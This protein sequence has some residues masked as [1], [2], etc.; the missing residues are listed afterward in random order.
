MSISRVSNTP[1]AKTFLYVPENLS[2]AM[3]FATMISNSSFCPA[4]MKGKPGDVLLAIQMGAEI[5]LSPLQALQNIS[6]INGKPCVYG[7]AALAVVQNSPY[8]V[9]HREWF[10]GSL[11]DNNLVAFCGM[12]RKGCDEHVVSFGIEDAKRA[13]LWGKVGVWQ[14]YKPRMLQMRARGFCSRDTFADALRGL[15]FREEVED[16]EKPKYIPKANNSRIINEVQVEIVQEP[17]KIEAPHEKSLDEMIAEMQNA[18]SMDELEKTFKHHYRIN[19]RNL[20]LLKLLGEAKDKLK[21][22]FAERK[23]FVREMDEE[24]DIQQ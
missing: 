20:D 14:T 23:D 8:Y 19:M 11:E 4:P 24:E 1:I 5:G 10:E 12:T 21:E 17:E 16:Y 2:Q 7:D 22:K 9:S 3:E 15:N 18:Q 13:G 6:V